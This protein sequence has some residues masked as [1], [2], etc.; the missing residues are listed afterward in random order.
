MP[1]YDKYTFISSYKSKSYQ[2]NTGEISDL[3]YRK[4]GVQI[5]NL[6]YKTDKYNSNNI[7]LMTNGTNSSWS[8]IEI[9]ENVIAAKFEENIIRVSLT[10][11]DAKSLVLDNPYNAL[12]IAIVLKEE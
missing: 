11:G 1:S 12:G 5:S 9:G 7:E 2:S 8:Y 3:V 4:S 6:L 10:E